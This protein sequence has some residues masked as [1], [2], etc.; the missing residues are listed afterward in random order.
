MFVCN[1]HCQLFLRISGNML[2]NTSR[3]KIS[4]VP[5][6]GWF[7]SR[8]K[9]TFKKPFYVVSVSAFIFFILFV[10]PIRSLL[11]QR[12]RAG[13]SFRLLAF[14]TFTGIETGTQGPD[15]MSRP[16]PFSR[17]TSVCP[18][19][20]RARNSV[21]IMQI[22]LDSFK[23]RKENARKRKRLLAACSGVSK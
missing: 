8:N 7:A 13:S 16:G 3:C 23:K 17:A 9:Y 19:I 11:I 12:M 22:L 21:N 20:L 2:K 14:E 10:K 1:L 5:E 15:Y 6:E 18:E 4:I